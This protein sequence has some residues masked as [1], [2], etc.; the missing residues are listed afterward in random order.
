MHNTRSL[1]LHHI[2]KDQDEKPK[3]NRSVSAN[4]RALRGDAGPASLPAKVARL[5]PA[6]RR[7]ELVVCGVSGAGSSAAPLGLCVGGEFAG[8]KT[9]TVTCPRRALGE[10]HRSA[11]SVCRRGVRLASDSC[12]SCAR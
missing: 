9:C 12:L 4:Y 5:E 10:A 2:A 1:A 11:V 3:C 7:R 8:A 6:L